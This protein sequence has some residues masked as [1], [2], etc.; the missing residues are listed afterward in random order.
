MDFTNPNNLLNQA[1]KIVKDHSIKF[2]AME[3]YLEPE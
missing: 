2:E 3:S 1:V